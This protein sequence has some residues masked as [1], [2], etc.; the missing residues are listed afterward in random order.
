M[1]RGSGILDAHL[2]LLRS[3]DDSPCLAVRGALWVAAHVGSSADG[4]AWL[5]GLAPD[6]VRSIDKIARA[7]SVLSLRGTAMGALGLLGGSGSSARAMLAQS[8][9]NCPGVDGS[10]V[11]MSKDS[12]LDVEFDITT[13]LN[14][15]LDEHSV[16]VVVV[17]VRTHTHQYG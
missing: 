6:V 15:D 1:L 3:A 17:Q 16:A 11:G 14:P 8:G 9:W 4:F 5:V 2:A 7:A 12:R 13:A 10:Y